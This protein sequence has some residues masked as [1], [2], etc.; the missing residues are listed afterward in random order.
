MRFIT[1]K[2]LSRCLTLT[3]VIN[4]IKI[5]ISFKLSAWI[6]KS[7]VWGQPYSLII[8]PTNLCNLKC[9]ECPSGT[10]ELTRPLGS[11]NME[12][13]KRIIDEVSKQTFY[14]QLFFQGE[15]FINRHLLE[16]VEYARNKKMY[17]S[18]STNAH[19]IQNGMARKVIS[20]KMDQLIISIDGLNQETYQTYRVGGKLRKV[21]DALQL[22]N[23]ERSTGSERCTEFVLQFLVTKQNEHE[24]DQ[25]KSLAKKYK[26]DVALKTLQVYSIESAQQLLPTNDKYRRYKI[27]NGELV[28]KSKMKN[29]CVYLWE[30]SVITW[31]GIVVPCCFDKDGK[32]SFGNIS[33]KPLMEIW[34]SDIYH[35]FRKRIL[36]NRRGVDMCTNCTEGLK[37][38]R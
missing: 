18:V 34:H 21:I 20:S 26:A 27:K 4:L 11:M 6:G 31:N 7:I 24:I 35:Q 1:V 17:V 37:V 15:P 33:E 29:H 32:Y 16:M 23:E 10:G 9:P 36:S 3:R 38:Y 8:E 2:N 19:F 12:L 25:L 28:T 30:R 14:L 5:F 22:L 13:F